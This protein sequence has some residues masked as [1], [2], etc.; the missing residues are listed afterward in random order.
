MDRENVFKLQAIKPFYTKYTSNNSFRFVHLHYPL[1][2]EGSGQTD[3][4][5]ELGITG[6]LYVRTY[7]DITELSGCGG[8]AD[9]VRMYVHS[10]CTPLVH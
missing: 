7:M 2:A 9:D 4:A 3:A 5:S 6:W 1:Q 10:S 8:L